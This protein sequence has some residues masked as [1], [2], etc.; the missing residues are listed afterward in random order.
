[1]LWG[2]HSQ[3]NLVPQFLTSLAAWGGH[4]TQLRPMVVGRGTLGVVG[5]LV[6]P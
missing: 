2:T 4:V 6:L 5:K 1:M 3:D